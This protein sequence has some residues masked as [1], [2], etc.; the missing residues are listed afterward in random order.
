MSLPSIVWWQ[1]WWRLVRIQTDS[2]TSRIGKIHITSSGIIKGIQDLFPETTSGI[3][4]A[5]GLA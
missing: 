5:L 2:P 1:R 4:A 3:A